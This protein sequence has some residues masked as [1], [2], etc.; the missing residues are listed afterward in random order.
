[1]SFDSYEESIDQGK[2]IDYY[3]FTLGA[4][5]F[6]YCTA[7][8]NELTTDGYVWTSTAISDD[9]QKYSGESTSD[10][11]NVQMPSGLAVSQ[12]FMTRM[13]S[14]TMLLRI[15]RRNADDPERHVVYVGEVR[16]HDIPVPGICKLTIE[17]LSASMQRNGLRLAW[18][19]TCTYALY[20]EVTCKLPMEPLGVDI[21]AIEVNG[22]DVRTDVL[23]GYLDHRF[24]GGFV[25]WDAGKRGIIFHQIEQHIGFDIK[26][27]GVE[28][29][30]YPGLR[31]RVFPGCAR[32]T[33]ACIA[34]GNYDNYGGA[35]R[36]PGRSPFDGNPVFY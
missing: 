32:T 20:D 1:M 34:L 11:L 5:V 7:A 36:L 31:A 15:F 16:Q 4:N 33:E 25:R 27:F 3:E 18:Q 12:M 28:N 19:K 23:G 30:I 8:K 13:P 14:T 17:T 35:P 22:F 26:I 24:S 29:A 2:P 6:R 9:G 21:I 10:A